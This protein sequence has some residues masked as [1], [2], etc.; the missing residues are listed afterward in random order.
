MKQNVQ[1]NMLIIKHVVFCV[2]NKNYIVYSSNISCIYK[3]VFTYFIRC[4]FIKSLI[5]KTTPVSL[6]KVI[7]LLNVMDLPEFLLL[8]ALNNF[9][10]ELKPKQKLAPVA[11][12]GEEQRGRVPPS[13][14]FSFSNY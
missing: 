10:Y 14:F 1:H 9:F 6:S 5:L 12:T 4:H 11:D 7:V 3:E 8:W 2:E 13:F